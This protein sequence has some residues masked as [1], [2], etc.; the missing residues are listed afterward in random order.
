MRVRMCWFRGKQDTEE[1]GDNCGEIRKTTLGKLCIKG[2]MYT[3]TQSPIVGRGLKEKQH[4]HDL[5]PLRGLNGT[6]REKVKCYLWVGVYFCHPR[7]HN[8]TVREGKSL[9]GRKE[10]TYNGNVPWSTAAD[11]FILKSSLTTEAAGG[12]RERKKKIFTALGTSLI[13]RTGFSLTRKA[14]TV[15]MPNR[16]H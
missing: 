7:Q 2:A 16:T 12:L 13:M 3:I 14:K 15:K 8:G 4:E 10:K 11:R 9:L 1:G 6:A 5:R